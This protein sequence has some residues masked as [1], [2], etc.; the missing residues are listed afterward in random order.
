MQ[1][2]V[3]KRYAWLIGGQTIPILP[4]TLRPDFNEAKCNMSQRPCGI[5]FC[6]ILTDWNGFG[7]AMLKLVLNGPENGLKR[8]KWFFLEQVMFL[9]LLMEEIYGAVVEQ[10]PVK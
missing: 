1:S 10:L 7:T 9:A 4:N 3:W 5:G 8:V 2:L 6:E